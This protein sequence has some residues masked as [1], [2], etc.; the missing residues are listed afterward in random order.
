MKYIGRYLCTMYYKGLLNDKRLCN[1]IEKPLIDEKG[2]RKSLSASWRQ[3]MCGDL[4][5]L[6]SG[7]RARV[8]GGRVSNPDYIGFSSIDGREDFIRE[9]EMYLYETVEKEF[10]AML[11]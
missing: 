3:L 1:C 10:K 9:N 7:R 8:L 11:L 6:N 5:K 2:K 4:T